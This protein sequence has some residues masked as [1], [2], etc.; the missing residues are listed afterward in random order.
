MPHKFMQLYVL[1]HF[2]KIAEE[3]KQI[4]RKKSLIQHME[5]TYFCRSG[6]P[7]IKEIADP[8]FQEIEKSLSRR[9]TK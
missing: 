3:N 6:I 8:A 4:M 9:S 7:K 1:M 2:I 5:I